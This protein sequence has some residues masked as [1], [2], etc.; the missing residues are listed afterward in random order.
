MPCVLPLNG[1]QRYETDVVLQRLYGS[2][3]SASKPASFNIQFPCY[4]TQLQN[5]YRGLRLATSVIK[6]HASHLR[7]VH[8]CRIKNIAKRDVKV[9]GEVPH[10]VAYATYEGRD[11]GVNPISVVTECDW[12]SKGCWRPVNSDSHADPEG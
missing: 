3:E 2:F 12:H 11:R 1:T 7:V 6:A 9:H 10:P 5:F 4:P 8:N